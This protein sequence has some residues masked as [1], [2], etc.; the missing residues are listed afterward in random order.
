MN[1][2]GKKNKKN[3]KNLND[4]LINPDDALIELEQLKIDTI[5]AKIYVKPSRN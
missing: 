1:G 4:T 2:S 3:L 5:Y